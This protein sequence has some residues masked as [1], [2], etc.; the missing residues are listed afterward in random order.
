M[1]PPFV[2]DAPGVVLQKDMIGPGANT[3]ILRRFMYH[4]AGTDELLYV[5]RAIQR[6]I[7]NLH[8]INDP[9]T[10]RRARRLV[11]ND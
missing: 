10:R 4:F 1:A 8:R 3:G 2:H 6:A 11:Q 7:N 5:S 9:L